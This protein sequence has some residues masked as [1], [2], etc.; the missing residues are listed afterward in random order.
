MRYYTLANIGALVAM[1]VAV[2]NLIT[3][4]EVWILIAAAI[5]LV[6]LTVYAVSEKRR[7]QRQSQRP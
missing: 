1:A 5:A 4:R 2:I 3:F 6:A 7:M